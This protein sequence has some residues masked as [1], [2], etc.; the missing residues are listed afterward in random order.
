MGKPLSVKKVN[1][2]QDALNIDVADNRNI[3]GNGLTNSRLHLNS[4]GYGK[5][6]SKN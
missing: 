1:D 4:T 6:L 5:T 2:H 3:G